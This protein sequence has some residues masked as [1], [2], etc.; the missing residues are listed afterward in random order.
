MSSSR[1]VLSFRRVERR[2][3]LPSRMSFRRVEL[4]IR[5]SFRRVE[6]LFVESIVFSSSR[7]SFCRVECLFVSPQRLFAESPTP[8]RRVAMPIR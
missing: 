3:E 1:V 2:V 8:V 6:C 4:P 5:M 7:M